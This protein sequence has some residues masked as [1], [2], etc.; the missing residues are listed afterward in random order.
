[1]TKYPSTLNIRSG[2]EAGRPERQRSGILV[3]NE[4][5]DARKSLQTKKR[6]IILAICD[7]KVK[8]FFCAQG[9]VASESKAGNKG[10][11]LFL[12]EVSQVKP[13]SSTGSAEYI[14]QNVDAA[15]ASTRH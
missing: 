13:Q 8:K 3:R 10:L 5:T 14:D 1:M 6:F 7:E 4:S 12:A 9:H 11:E 15:G 2:L